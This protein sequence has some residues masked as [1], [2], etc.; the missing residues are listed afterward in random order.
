ME[1]SNRRY[2]SDGLTWA[3]HL[4]IFIFGV[5]LATLGAILPALVERVG[6]NPAEAGSLFLFLSFGALVVTLFGGPAIDRYGYRFLLVFSGLTCAAGLAGLAG[7]A[8]FPALVIAS[9]LL[10]LG[11]GGLNTGTNALVAELYPERPAVA[12]NRLGVFFGLGT[13]AIPLVI[14]MLVDRLGLSGILYV[15]AAFSA[16]CALIYLVAR[17]PRPKQAG[18]FPFRQALDMFRHPLML[19]L[20]L[21]LF[22]QSGNEITTGG[23][24]TTFAVERL[25]ASQAGASFYLTAFWGA[26]VLGRFAAGWALQRMAP[27]SVVQTG[28]LGAGL[29][30]ALL[31]AVGGQVS[32][33]FLSGL[34]GFFMALIF[35]TVIGIASSRYP[36]LS[37]TV[38]GLLM[39]VALTGGMLAPLLTG[40]VASTV[41]IRLALLLPCCGFLIVCVLQ[42]FA[43][44]Y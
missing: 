7:V 35:P 21:L 41:G 31:L 34:T 28:A 15:T 8:G 17:L 23:W 9:F 1:A 18:G 44:R 19:L 13:F 38:I 10:G 37:G 43:R 30:L 27:A 4:G 26:L 42:G 25:G 22:F 6:M 40:V 33:Y 3:A 39:A 16:A 32:G 20:A 11:G 2:W 24:L 29:A 36:E 14:G 5:A 12:L